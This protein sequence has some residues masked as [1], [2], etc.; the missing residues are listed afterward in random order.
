MG[1][2]VQAPLGT[3]FE[4][5]DLVVGIVRH[6]DPV[7]CPACAVGQWDMCRNGLYTERGIKQRDGFGSEFYTV[8]PT[9]LV[10]IDPSLG[11]LGVLLEPTTVVAKAW[12]QVEKIGNRA[13]WDPHKVVVIGA[14]PIGLLAALLGVQKGLDVYVVD[15]VNTGLKPDLVQQLGAHYY[16]GPL[17]PVLKD[18]DVVIECSGVGHVVFD[19]IENVGSYS[20]VC[21]TG[22]SASG[23]HLDLDVGAISRGVVLENQTV[24]GSVNANRTHYEMA[25]KA[26]DKADKDW[27]GKIITR[28]VHIDNFEQAFEHNVDDVKVIIEFLH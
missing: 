27:L 18:A 4:K 6:P 28:K 5:D 26:L 2:V 12:E 23:T 21:L 13:Y 8:E 19:V 7:P 24:V 17:S 9:H 22:V 25:A 15:V 10:K 16:V 20:V 11:I 14:G 1:K 3:E